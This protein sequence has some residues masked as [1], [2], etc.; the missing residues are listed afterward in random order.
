MGREIVSDKRQNRESW[1][2]SGTHCIC[3]SV[4]STGQFLL[5][6]RFGKNSMS[7]EGKC[8]WEIDNAGCLRGFDV[9]NSCCVLFVRNICPHPISYRLP[10]PPSLLPNGRA[11]FCPMTTPKLASNGL[12]MRLLGNFPVSQVAGC[13]CTLLAGNSSTN[14]AGSGEQINF[15]QKSSKMLKKASESFIHAL[16]LFS[17]FFSQNSRWVPLKM[18]NIKVKGLRKR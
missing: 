5:A 12:D 13:R 18:A 11:E 9:W 2:C 1:Q 10:P 8:S 3:S 16:L 15:Y 17:S 14:L 7:L 4:C 6:G